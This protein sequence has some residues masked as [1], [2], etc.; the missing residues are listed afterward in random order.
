MKKILAGQVLLILCCAFYLV[1]W[2]RGYRPGTS[3]NRVGGLNGV[4]LFITAA[5]GIAGIVCSLG[6][7]EA[8]TEP[9]IDPSTILVV[10]LIAYFVLMIV[11][12]YAFR[13]IVT[14]ELLLIVGWCVLEMTVINRLF[15]GGILSGG[16]FAAMC[17][18]LAAAFLISMVL[19]VAYYRMEEMKAFYAAM[20]PLIT[21]ALSMAVLTGIVLI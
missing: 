18:V 7:I 15:A 6:R 16:G 14:T 10:G 8:K 21:E 17:V 9:K 5:L 1:W 13:R 19:Y 2:Y 4:L 11:T 3:V 20:I 12:R